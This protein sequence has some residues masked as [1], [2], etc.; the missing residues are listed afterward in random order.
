LEL[1]LYNDYR[2]FFFVVEDY[3]YWSFVKHTVEVI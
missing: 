2:A 3:Q 1:Y